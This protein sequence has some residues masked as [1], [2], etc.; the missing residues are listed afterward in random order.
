MILP[1]N[2]PTWTWLSWASENKIDKEPVTNVC[3]RAKKN[4][5][6]PLDG[7]HTRSEGPAVSIS[8]V[9]E[10][11]QCLLAASAHINTDHATH[12]HLLP[13]I[14]LRLPT[15]VDPLTTRLQLKQA[16]QKTPKLQQKQEHRQF[17]VKRGKLKT[18]KVQLKPDL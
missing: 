8:K 16:L 11:T 17:Q 1:A 18:R 14:L 13:A 12:R 9:I 6:E 2:Q 4:E 7:E 10:S 5:A 3:E 15:P